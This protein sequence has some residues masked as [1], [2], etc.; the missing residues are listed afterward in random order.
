MS[1]QPYE[2]DTTETLEIL[3]ASPF[4]A[5]LDRAARAEIADDLQ[6]VSL[7]AGQSLFQQGDPGDS[8]Y[9]VES[10]LLEVRTRDAA[11]ETQVLDRLDA[12]TAV[13]EMAL[14][15]GQPRT[16][17][18]V[19]VV[20]SRL[21]RIARAGFDRL[22]SKNP[23]IAS[24]FALAVT[25]RIQRLK[26][27]V[28]F[29]R[30]FGDMDPLALHALQERITWRRLSSGEALIRQGEIG[31]SMFVV[32]N[33]RLQIVVEG[34][35]G[36]GEK[37]VGEVGTGETV[38]EFA[39]LTDD[40]RSATIY[41]SRDT[42]VVE[43]T[44]PVFDELIRDR[45]RAMAEIARLI[46]MRQKRSIRLIPSDLPGAM[47]IAI[48]P[49]GRSGAELVEFAGRLRES[50]AESGST[51][52]FTSAQFDAE[53]GK[54]GAAQTELDDAL[55]IVINSWLQE[56]EYHY[57][58]ILFVA[59]GD[60]SVWTQRCLAQSDSILLVGRAGD[61]PALNPLENYCSPRTRKELVL[62]HDDGTRQP[63]GTLA[64]LVK[65][66]VTAH[67]HV[68]QGDAAH[69]GRL[70]RRLTGKAVAAVFSGGAARGLAHIG[71]IRAFDE[72]GLAVDFIGG[73]SMGAFIS[74]GWA[75]GLTPADGMELARKMANP[76]YL[77]DRTF[78][79]TSVMA[80][81]KM[82]AAIREVLGEVNIEDL[83]RPFFCVST[84]LSIAA[85][86]VHDRGPLWRAVRASIALPGIFSPILNEKN[87]IL[88]D[89]GVMNNFPVDIMA[90]RA[91]FGLI[92]GCNVSPARENPTAYVLGDS[93]SG[94]KVLWSRINPFAK[95]M[96]VPTLA[97]TMLR[98]VEVNS[99]YNRKEAQRYADILIEPDTL[100]FNFLAFA[101]YKILEQRGY[102]AGM[103]ALASW[104]QANAADRPERLNELDQG[105]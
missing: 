94:W 42:D 84:N 58:H 17:D 88:T 67:H 21:L 27:A 43:I 81:R 83:W 7:V 49:A 8:M 60:W 9:I 54:P 10:G 19:A 46:V 100:G 89:G 35:K 90:S 75:A 2:P 91:E 29:G 45:P 78:P 26:L 36:G 55:S 20:D 70:A 11:G 48:V 1:D 3:S 80:S 37:T 61:D 34:D 24:G 69:W 41:A 6:I 14:L 15:T 40:V 65:R 95:T 101:D 82:T 52:V 86:V 50:L 77:L 25:P 22:A 79:Y 31:T 71:V 38:G 56:Q 53:F 33:G 64:W 5:R 44:R 96:N 87:E 30:L 104:Q 99:L 72:V 57:R 4:F 74:G 85:P 98:T 73:T 105:A 32:V 12:G 51:A 18:V 63:S 16:A 92:I 103:A 62:I 76:D 93:L 66:D 68:R 59:D 97:G 47:T 102:E 39:L 28:I 23:A 13:G